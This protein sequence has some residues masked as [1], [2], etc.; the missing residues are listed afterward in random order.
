ML[1]AAKVDWGQDGVEQDHI[2]TR[3]GRLENKVMA[4]VRRVFVER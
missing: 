2:K 4:E 1:Y 3:V